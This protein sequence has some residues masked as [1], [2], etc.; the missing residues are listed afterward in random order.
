M[1]QSILVFIAVLVLVSA[2]AAISFGHYLISDTAT[3]P[4][5]FYRTAA[6]YIGLYRRSDIVVTLYTNRTGSQKAALETLVS[7]TFRARDYHVQVRHQPRTKGSHDTIMI[8]V[9]ANSYGPYHT[10][11]AGAAIQVALS[12]QSMRNR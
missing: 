6:S 5:D 10:S 3:R 4:F 8:E 2:P 12:A 1:R 11:Q 9:G 7:N